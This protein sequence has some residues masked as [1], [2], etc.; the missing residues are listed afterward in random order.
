MLDVTVR[1]EHE[2]L[3]ALA[4]REA[5]RA[6]ARSASPATT[7]GPRR[8]RRA[9]RDRRAARPRAPAASARCSPSGLPR[10]RRPDSSVTAPGRARTGRPSVH[11]REPR[12]RVRG[13]ARGRERRCPTPRAGGRRRGRT[14]GW[15]PRRASRRRCARPH[16]SRCRCAGPR[17]WPRYSS[18]T[19]SECTIDTSMSKPPSALRSCSTSSAVRVDRLAERP[20]GAPVRHR[21][22]SPAG[23]AAS[24]P[25]RRRAA[26]APA[27]RRRRR[28]HRRAAR[29]CAE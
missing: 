6:P 15:P 12:R 17:I 8:R 1:V 29:R 20:G 10:W 27:R 26:C 18:L 24:S 2:Q 5:G 19:P 4:R 25:S 7:A 16:R 22:P 3:G 13:R 9:P 28:A 11:P 23:T 21:H 14:C